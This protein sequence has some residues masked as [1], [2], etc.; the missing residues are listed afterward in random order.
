MKK[1]IAVA[2]IVC[3]AAIA[4]ASTI[5]WSST[6]MAAASQIKGPDG[7]TLI[8]TWAGTTGNSISSVILM[9]AADFSQSELLTALRKD[10]YTWGA[11]ALDTTSVN[12]SSKIAAKT[13]GELTS[14]AGTSVNVYYAILATDAEGNKSV[15][16]ST[17]R[18]VDVPS[19][20]GATGTAAWNADGGTFSALKN[21]DA[22]Y[23]AAGWYA[24]SSAP[25]PIPGGV[26]EPTSGLLVLLGVAGLA[27]R[28]RA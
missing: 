16:L 6:T 24:V 15:L 28:R 26:P 19:S 7:T 10:E 14:L 2:A 27:L 25:E 18:S 9:N 13:S 5:K 20:E 8:N 22:A 23:S 3:V 11:G 4:Q 12:S 1:L 21:G 17:S